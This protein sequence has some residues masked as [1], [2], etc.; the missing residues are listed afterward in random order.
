MTPLK[1]VTGVL[2][3][4]L[5]IIFVVWAPGLASLLV[6]ECY[7]E[8]TFRCYKPDVF[9]LSGVILIGYS[10]KVFVFDFTKPSP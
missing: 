3:L 4:L 1:F 10:I 9:L 6:I 2:S 7:K 5:G 8:W